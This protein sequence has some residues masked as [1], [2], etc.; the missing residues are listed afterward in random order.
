[1]SEGTKIIAKNSRARFEYEILDR[2]EAGICLQG[3]EVKS[4]RE[5]NASIAE[6]FAR[7]EDG[8]VYLY[9]M[10]IPPYE[11]G[12]WMNHD[13]VRRRK[14]LLHRREIKRLIGRV[15]EKGLTLVPL[16]A[17]FKRGLAKIEIGL[18]RGKR[19][20]DKRDSIRRRDD[21]R[22]VQRELHARR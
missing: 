7:V 6:S 14:L 13:P 21:E 8:E 3:T 4:L 19:Q 16:S 1:M 2:F 15:A 22:R 17:Y 9:S 20:Y 18:V 11:R 5:A 10:H 12:S